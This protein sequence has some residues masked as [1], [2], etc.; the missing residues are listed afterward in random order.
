[1]AVR[2]IRYATIGLDHQHGFYQNRE[3]VEAGYELVSF[4]TSEPHHIARHQQEFPHVPLARSPE[5]ILEDESIEMINCAAVNSERAGIG[6]NAMQH[7]KD[8]IVDK[9]GVTTFEQLDA[10]KK[11]Q[12]ET[13]KKY[14]IWFGERLSD[15]STAKASELVKRGEI[16]RVLQTVGLGPHRLKIANP[17]PA[18][19]FQRAKFGG[20]LVD[21]CSHQL[22]QFLHFTGSSS[23]EV[24]ASQVG[25]LGHPEHPELEDFGDVMV[26]GDGGTGYARL[27]WFTPNGLGSWGDGR[28]FIL[29][30]DGTIELRK[31]I[32]VAGRPSKDNLFIFNQ[33]ETRYVD[34]T[35]TPLMFPA[36]LAVDIRNRTEQAIS[37]RHCFLVAEL[38]LTAERDAKKLG[39]LAS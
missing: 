26:R 39:Y 7:G 36:Q 37:Q 38:G 6:I 30:T 8:F 2:P 19:F 20:I 25:N 34:C 27:D 28:L 1:M 5:E 13:N 12:A 17:R 32:D 35:D 3:L 18:W 33:N 16:G 24:V 11:V 23:A 31:T 29:G 14:L 4:W 22:D 9:P 10:V 21:I 15:K